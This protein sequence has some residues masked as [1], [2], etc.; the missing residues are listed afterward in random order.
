LIEIFWLSNLIGK[1]NIKNSEYQKLN[2][3]FQQTRISHHVSC[4]Y[5][6]QQMDIVPCIRVLSVWMLL[7][8]G[9]T[10]SK[11]YPNAGAHLCAEILL[12]THLSVPTPGVKYLD[13]SFANVHTPAVSTNDSSGAA[14]NLVRTEAEQVAGGGDL[15]VVS[16][17]PGVDS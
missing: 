6:H 8:V 11:L 13:D 2:A 17:V 16:S 12:P 15:A 3:F 4:P 7:M 5:A 14:E 9:F 1:V 10:F